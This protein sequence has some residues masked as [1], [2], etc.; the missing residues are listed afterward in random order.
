[1]TTGIAPQCY[2]CSRLTL[3]LEPGV[4]WSCEAFPDGIPKDILVNRFDHHQPYRGDHGLR[5]E[6]RAIARAAGVIILAP[7]GRALLLRRSGQSDSGGTW[8]FPGGG[9]EGDETPEQA[10]RRE[11]EEEIGTCP[12]SELIPWTR[13]IKDGVDFTTFLGRVDDEFVPRLNGE[14]DKFQWVDV[15][16]LLKESNGR[17]DAFEESEHPRD[18]DGKFTAGSGEHK[19]GGWSGKVRA[20]WDT[21]KYELVDPSETATKIWDEIQ[22]QPDAEEGWKVNPLPRAQPPNLSEQEKNNAEHGGGRVERISPSKFVSSQGRIDP[23]KLVKLTSLNDLDDLDP[24]TAVH[25]ED[26][27]QVIDGNHRAALAQMMNVPIR[28]R[29]LDEDEGR[30]D[31]ALDRAITLLD[32]LVA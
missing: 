12:A 15:K 3:P 10:A 9:I 25:L 4:G 18:N 7:G 31:S 6:P 27:V 20:N 11:C 17:S 23:V 21:G 1:M 30:S 2:A 32:R 26:K 22:D 29:F 14:H 24:I 13:R 28:V 8:S 19:F 5:F 16:E